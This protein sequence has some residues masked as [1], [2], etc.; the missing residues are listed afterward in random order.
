MV[1]ETQIPGTAEEIHS[2]LAQLAVDLQT[3]KEF[4]Q[5]E[6]LK[7]KRYEVFCLINSFLSNS[8]K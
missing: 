5:D 7:Y 1:E 3:N 4:L 2:T 6:Q 8:F